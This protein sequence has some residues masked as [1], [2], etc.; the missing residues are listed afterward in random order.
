MIGMIFAQSSNG[1]IGRD[2]QLLFQI[3]ED[4][5]RFKELTTGAAV[6]MG[7]KT[8]ESLPL[9]FK[10][11]PDRLN[12]I[13]SN[14]GPYLAY[15]TNHFKGLEGAVSLEAALKLA[16]D[17]DHQDI[18]IIGGETVYEEGMKYA[19]VIHQTFVTKE[20]DGDA[21]APFIDPDIWDRELGKPFM[22]YQGL[23]YQF[24]VFKRKRIS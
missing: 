22:E 13:L 6:I 19:D 12:V 20:F 9:R 1:Y 10:P 24:N 21:K 7:R 14:D 5:K 8:W 16:K 18:W 15:E 17:L 11:L 3:P 2:G 23:Y 4:M